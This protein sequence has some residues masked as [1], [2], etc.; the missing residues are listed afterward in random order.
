MSWFC[1]TLIMTLE[2]LFFQASGPRTQAQL[3]LCLMLSRKPEGPNIPGT[4]SPF[5]F[6]MGDKKC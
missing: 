2:C 1:P 4:L 3:R 5:F 6:L